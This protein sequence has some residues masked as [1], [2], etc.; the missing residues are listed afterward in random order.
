MADKPKRLKRVV[1]YVSE[2]EHRRL[3]MKLLGK[4]KLMSDWVR[5][6]VQEE[7]NKQDNPH[8]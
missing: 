3:R 1:G 7:I 6:K 2:D 4:G 8:N 5:E